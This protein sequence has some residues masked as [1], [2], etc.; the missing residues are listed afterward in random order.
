M[1]R[2]DILFYYVR[3]EKLCFSNFYSIGTSPYIWVVIA[4]INYVTKY[5]LNY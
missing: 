2:V 1:E 5:M 4:M 3:Y